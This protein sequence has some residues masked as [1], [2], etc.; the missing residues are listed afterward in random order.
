MLRKLLL[1]AS[2]APLALAAC[3]DNT[4]PVEN[5][6]L[7]V[8]FQ[9]NAGHIHIWESPVTYS[10]TATTTGT[11]KLQVTDFDTLRV[12]YAAVGTT[13]WAKLG[14]LRLRST[15]Y[16]DTLYWP[17]SGTFNYRLVGHRAGQ[18][19]VQ[20]LSA[21]ASTV[22]P[23]RQHFDV[24][25]TTWRVEFEPSPGM[26][27][28]GDTV[29]EKFFVMQATANPDGTRTPVTGLTGLTITCLNPGSSTGTDNAATEGAGGMYT[30]TCTVPSNGWARAR[31]NFN[32]GATPPQ[33]GAYGVGT[34]SGTPPTS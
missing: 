5:G 26:N 1:I 14:D 13:A 17:S 34:V 24:A 8:V 29:T 12:E 16:M 18:A 23:V 3:K 28:P 21:P 31:L 7:D 25:G 33:T 32:S 30:A 6:P 2:L 22:A 10:A 9:T 4:A 11:P 19:G 15:F 27:K 20:V